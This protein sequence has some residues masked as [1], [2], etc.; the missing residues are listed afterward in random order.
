MP[1]PLPQISALPL[2]PLALSP[3]PPLSVLLQGQDGPLIISSVAH[4]RSPLLPALRLRQGVPPLLPSN[5]PAPL[6]QISALSFQQGGPR[7]QTSAVIPPP[8]ISALFLQ[9]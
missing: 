2:Q 3:P 7:L 6:A 8:P 4:A 9:Q 1:A 5:V